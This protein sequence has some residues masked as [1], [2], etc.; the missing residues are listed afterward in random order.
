MYS[1]FIE[2]DFNSQSVEYPLNYD[3]SKLNLGY[4]MEKNTDLNGSFYITPYEPFFIR[5]FEVVTRFS[6]AYNNQINSLG[7]L[8]Y[9]SNVNWIVYNNGDDIGSVAKRFFLSTYTK[10]TKIFENIGSITVNAPSN[11]SHTSY[12]I[13]PSMEYH[14]GGTVSVN[15]TIVNGSGTT[16]VTDGVCAGNRI[17]FGS[18]ISSAI[19]EWF[20]VVAVSG[21]T[22]LIIGKEY[23]FDGNTNGL[24]YPVGTPYVIEDF[25]I[26]YSN[27]GAGGATLRGIGLVKGLRYENF[28]VTPTAIPVATTVDNI[29]AGYRILDVTGTTA[30]FTPI[31][32]ILEDK[33]TLSN[34]N[35]FSLSYPATTTS[36]VQ[37]FN[38]RAPL[39]VTAGRSN[40]PFLLTTGT[41]SHGGTNMGFFNSFIKG[42]N[43]NYYVNYYTRIGRIVP[44][45]IV[46]GSTTFI[47][48]TMV[49]N[50]PGSATTFNTSSQLQGFHYLEKSQR[51]YIPNLQGTFRNYVTPYISGSTTNFERVALTNN[52]VQT[53]TY[54]VSS[55]DQPTANYISAPIRSYYFDGLSYLVRDLA[56]N[57]NVIYTLPL[58]VDKQY[59]TTTNAY[60]VTPE[61]ST[62]SATTYNKVYVRSKSY[63][64]E[65]R[66]IMPT[67]NFDVY[68][69]TSGIT[70]DT[71]SWVL[72]GQNGNISP[73]SG[74]SIQFKITFQTIGNNC[75]PT[76]IYGI[77]MSYYSNE[78][79]KSLTFYEPSLKFSNISNQIFAWR[80]IAEFV[81]Q[82]PN[83]NIN[84]YN[85]NSNTLLLTD[86]VSGS[87]NGVWEYSSNEGVNWN[88]FSYSAN[89]INNYIRYTPNS[90]LGSGIKIKPIIYI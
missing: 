8:K 41:Q 55:I 44:A 21:E 73:A 40:S 62:P 31:G 63:F 53:N 68:Y 32:L 33:T 39:S 28:T 80:Q 20:K 2:Y 26:I 48:D 43:N 29:R 83:L 38:I 50:P 84:V 79:P 16:W 30:T 72:I 54:T 24:T 46:S 47:S 7:F 74:T 70:T 61:F 71:G 89:S 88:T 86:N 9:N 52:T 22:S 42:T 23:S 27:Y 15:S 85:V 14:T 3:S 77:T 76:K 45:N 10:S 11:V 49:E 13:T 64:N 5:G 37:K 60:V 51:F 69:R 65:D 25:R 58:E 59:H 4:L 57:N 17:G 67:E 12:S 19:T 34:Q 87:T 6:T 18:T 56:T 1:N 36:S 90:S 81:N 66:F 35:L 78:P 75:I 82:I